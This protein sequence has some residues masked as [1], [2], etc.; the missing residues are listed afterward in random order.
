MTL[1]ELAMICHYR[2]FWRTPY[3]TGNLAAS[4]GDVSGVV[5][6][7]VAGATETVGFK[8]FNANQRASYGKILNEA[9]T[10]N[11]RAKNVHTGKIYIGSYVNRHY[12]WLDNF[13][14]EFANDIPLYFPVRRDV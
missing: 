9:Q 12:R 6:H 13:A 4:V 14:A 2:M 10:I 1:N 7:G 5:D 11:Y 3:R 8:P